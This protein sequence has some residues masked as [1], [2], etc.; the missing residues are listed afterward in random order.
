[1]DPA[2]IAADHPAARRLDRLDADGRYRL[3]LDQD[4]GLLPVLDTESGRAYRLAVTDPAAARLVAGLTRPVLERLAAPRY[5]A[6]AEADRDIGALVNAFRVQLAR[7]RAVHRD[8]AALT[9]AVRAQIGRAAD[10]AQAVRRTAFLG[11]YLA[12]TDDAGDA[13]DLGHDPG[14]EDGSD[15]AIR[16]WYRYRERIR[17][18]VLPPQLSPQEIPRRRG[19]G[20]FHWF[21]DMRLL[22]GRTLTERQMLELRAEL[23]YAHVEPDRVVLDEWSRPAEHPIFNRSDEIIAKYGFDVALNFIQ[24]GLRGL[25]LRV[26]AALADRLAPYAG[27][28][29]LAVSAR[30]AGDALLVRLNRQEEDGENSYER[31]DPR[32]WL[33][34]LLPLRDALV[35]GDLRA[36]Y[37]AWRARETVFGR[38]R[39]G[40]PQP[41]VPPLLDEDELTEPLQ[42][43][44][45][46]LEEVP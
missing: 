38:P 9:R 32:P 24:W 46:L 25:W 7:L 17:A 45:R 5:R 34:E 23:P 37:I 44:I 41:P 16:D 28:Y 30:P 13:A 14:G 36:P 4:A 26:P 39:R 22:D 19:P 42:A 2:Q 29:G 20:E 15:A 33:D 27:E 31:Y 10:E 43:L 1:M 35:A 6:R 3:W 11:W 40:R 21:S 8:R 12:R 18:T